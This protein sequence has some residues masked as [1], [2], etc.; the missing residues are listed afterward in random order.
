M[1]KCISV[2]VIALTV[3]MAIPAQAQIKLGVKGGLNLAE[4]S[5]SK[6]DLK[7]NNFTGFFI[8]PMVDI[9]IPIV[10]LGVDGSLLYS[11][12]GVKFGSK[13]GAV[14]ETV[15]Q[16]GIEVPINLKYTFGLGSLAGIYIAAGP[17]FFFNLSGDDKISSFSEVK[18][19]N[20]QLA[21]NLGAGL[22][23]LNHLQLGVNYNMPLNDSAKFS[24]ALHGDSYK[25]KTWQVSVAY[26]F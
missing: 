4:A 19:K 10:G 5:F 21:I 1:K 9:T 3:G 20:A 17:S 24:D 15:K 16:N 25:T 23:L 22:K 13:D 26:I 11:Q 2:L 7:T 12:K 6:D 8:G 14:D 18:M